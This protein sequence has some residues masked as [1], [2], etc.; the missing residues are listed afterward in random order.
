MHPQDALTHALAQARNAVLR[1]M[2]SGD[3]RQIADAQEF[4][5]EVEAAAKHFLGSYEIDHRVSKAWARHS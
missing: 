2:C 1:A 3:A 5:K 4:L